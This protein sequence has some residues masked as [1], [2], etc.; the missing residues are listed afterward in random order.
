MIYGM[1]LLDLDY[2]KVCRYLLESFKGSS[3]TISKPLKLEGTIPDELGFI[4]K[5]SS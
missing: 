4:A 1:P 5:A 3:S 2:I